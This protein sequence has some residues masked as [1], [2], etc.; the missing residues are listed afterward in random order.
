MSKFVIHGGDF[1]KGGTP[2]SFSFGYF[3]LCTVAHQ[4]AGESVSASDIDTIE[5]LTEAN[6]K[7]LSGSLAWGAVGAI[8]LGP[9]GGLAGLLAGGNG[10][11]VTFACQFKDGRK[12]VAT[13]D[14]KTYAKIRGAAL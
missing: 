13:V 8:A 2:P 3:R 4:W 11:D 9:I 6:A 5:V 10:S 12:L 1:I 14:S 7:R